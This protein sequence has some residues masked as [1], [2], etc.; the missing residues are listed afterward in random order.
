MWVK[1]CH[2][3]PFITSFTGG[4]N[5]PFPVMGGLFMALFY[6][7]KMGYSEATFDDK[8]ELCLTFAK[9]LG[10]AWPGQGDGYVIRSCP[11][12]HT[13]GLEKALGL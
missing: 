11:I 9:D 6:P 12:W 10:N 13:E 1:Q 8:G 5:F 4:I 2:K 3:P 7:Q